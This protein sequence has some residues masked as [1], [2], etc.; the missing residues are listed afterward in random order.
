MRSCQFPSY[1]FHWKCFPLFSLINHLL[2]TP[3]AITN[4]FSFSLYLLS[5]STLLEQLPLLMCKRFFSP[6]PI[7]QGSIAVHR[8]HSS[9]IKQKEIYYRVLGTYRFLGTGERT[10]HECHT[11][12]VS[13]K[14]ECSV[15]SWGCSSGKSTAAATCHSTFMKVPPEH[16]NLCDSCCR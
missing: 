16:Q 3:L 8:A 5:S 10:K 13:S 14:E 1:P 11:A 7:S 6:L 15:T 4:T 9:L 2:G 12:E